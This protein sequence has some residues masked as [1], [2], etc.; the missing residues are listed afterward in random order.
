MS[1]RFVISLDFELHWGTRERRPWHQCQEEIL[2]GRDA[3]FQ[4]LR[5]FEARAIHATWAVVGFLFARGK[6]DALRHAPKV[7]PRYERQELD[8]YPEL[9]SAGASEDQDP[10][11]FASSIVET[12]AKAKHQELATHTFSHYYCLEPGQSVE[13]FRADLEAART[14]GEAYGE[15]VRS[16]VFPRNQ[17][18]L[19]YLREA[20]EAGVLCYRGNPQRWFWQ[21]RP[22]GEE[23]KAQRIARLADAYLPGGDRAVQRPELDPSGLVNVPATQFLRPWHPRA[24]FADGMRRRRI[25]EQMTRAAR[26]QGLFH[27]WWHPNNFSR[28]IQKNIEFLESVLDDFSVLQR[29]YAMRSSTMHEIAV[30]FLSNRV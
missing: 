6:A 29:Q 19:P 24:S 22:S 30:D 1:G 23:S 17:F 25:R 26:D 5:V 2:A 16:I 13:A 28:D 7:K 27:L 18:A 3:V 8:P 21:P 14:I 4:I 10:F 9:D 15:V 20:R 11:H 12:I